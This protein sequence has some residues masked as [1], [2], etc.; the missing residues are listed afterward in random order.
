MASLSKTNPH[1][2]G[3][4]GSLGFLTWLLLWLRPNCWMALSADQGSSR[5][6]WQRRRWLGTLQQQQEDMEVVA[7]S[8]AAVKQQ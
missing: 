2:S 7:A 6:M 5:V 1:H 3:V 8:A 4:S